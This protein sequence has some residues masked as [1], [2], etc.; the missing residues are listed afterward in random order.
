MKNKFTLKN[1]QELFTLIKQL[2]TPISYKD[3]E[4]YTTLNVINPKWIKI[5]EDAGI[6]PING[7]YPSIDSVEMKKAFEGKTIKDLI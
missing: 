2:S 6:Y 5:C 1:L 7:E 3:G 4:I